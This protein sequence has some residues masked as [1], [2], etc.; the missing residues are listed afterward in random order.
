MESLNVF[1]KCL[2]GTLDS[3]PFVIFLVMVFSDI[4]T[5]FAKGFITGKPSSAAGAKGIAKHVAEVF[6]VLVIAMTFSMLDQ[7][8]YGTI[9]ILAMYAVEGISLI[10]NLNAMGV[11][12]PNWLVE[13]FGD[14]KDKTPKDGE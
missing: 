6:G 14:V 1:F 8:A 9:L 12:L 13:Y 7:D 4:V 3:V 2:A 11:P 5:G 10:G